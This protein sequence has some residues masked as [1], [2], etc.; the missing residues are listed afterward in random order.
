[1]A[2]CELLGRAIVLSLNS[3]WNV[4]YMYEYKLSALIKVL[5]WYY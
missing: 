3:I 2:Q 1:M 4:A 5:R